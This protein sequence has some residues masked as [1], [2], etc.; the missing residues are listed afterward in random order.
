LL[1]EFHSME[2]IVTSIL[3]FISTN[4]DDIFILTLFF[5]NKRFKPREIIVGQYLGI[6]GLI[7]ISFIASLAGLVIDKMYIGLLGLIPI[8]LGIKGLI[9]LFRKT[10]SNESSEELELDHKRS[11]ILSVAGVTIANGGDNIGIYT[12]IFA[13]LP[14]SATITM[15]IIFLVMTMLWCLIAKYL[16][17]HPYIARIIDKYG[18]MVTPLVLIGLGIFILYESGSLGLVSA[19][20]K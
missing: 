3:A 13:A 9:E 18:H 12:P 10:N 16:T 15:V 4:I 6:I 20:I 8:Y 5:G 19:L 1:K 7:A 2:L 17:K 14:V 11:N